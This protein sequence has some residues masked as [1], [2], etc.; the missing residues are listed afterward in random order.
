M[1]EGPGS[2]G[3]VLGGV[4]VAGLEGHS[5]RSAVYLVHKGLGRR[6]ADEGRMGPPGVYFN[7]AGCYHIRSM[8]VL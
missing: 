3:D 1:S 2:L 5:S 7:K 8:N 6:H 4:Q